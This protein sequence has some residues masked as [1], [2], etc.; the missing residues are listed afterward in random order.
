MNKIEYNDMLVFHP[1]Y[2]IREFVEN[3]G[4]SI[5]ELSKKLDVETEILE[6]LIEGEEEVT[7]ILANRLSMVFETSVNFWINTQKKFNDTKEK[8]EIETLAKIK[9]WNTTETMT[10]TMKVIFVSLIKK[11]RQSLNND[12]NSSFNHLFESENQKVRYTI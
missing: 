2:Y 9:G 7:E 11:E 6:K 12:V 10:K 1:G 3:E 4:I 8:L 5:S